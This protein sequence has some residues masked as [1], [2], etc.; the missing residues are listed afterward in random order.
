MRSLYSKDTEGGNCSVTESLH[1][2]IVPLALPKHSTCKF[3]HVNLRE[4]NDLERLTGRADVHMH[5]LA[6]DGVATAAQLLD[7]VARKANLDVIAI[8]DHDVL[9]ASLWA[10]E[11]RAS[12]PF[13]IIPGVE[14]SARRAHVLGL[15]VTQTV[16]KNLSI[17]ETVAAIHE[18]GGVAIL[19]HPGEPSIN[20]RNV[21][22]YLR[23][24]E[25][26][27]EWGLDAI[28]VFNAG[29]VTPGNN[30]IARFIAEQSSLARVGNSD[31]HTL[32]AIGL[33]TTCFSGRTA[34]DFRAALKAGQTA[35]EGVR[36]PITDYLKLS[37]SSIPR[38]RNKSL[39]TSSLSI[40]P[41]P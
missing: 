39:T 6:S 8:T 10:Y 2:F 18:Q 40:R 11:Q 9:E 31:A 36:W 14:V 30:I 26:L 13:G 38:R 7:Y 29:T 15:W 16:P 12:Y 22:C 32:S 34:A 5:T 33:G 27:L 37:M 3:H 1:P 4:D 24:P 19:A 28:E 35:V 23:H 21:L 20:G 17:S 25:V 41:A